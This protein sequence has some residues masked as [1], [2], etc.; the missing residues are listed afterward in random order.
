MIIHL[1]ISDLKNDPRKEKLTEVAL[2]F[3]GKAKVSSNYKIPFE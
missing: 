3:E 2:A 1:K